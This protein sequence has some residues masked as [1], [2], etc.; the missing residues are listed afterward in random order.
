MSRIPN[1]GFNVAPDPDPGIAFFLK[2]LNTPNL[3]RFI[4]IV[5]QLGTGGLFNLSSF[6]D[7]TGSRKAKIHAHPDLNHRAPESLEP[8]RHT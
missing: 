8:S 1:T 5:E 7:E 3:K 6:Y 4:I 2:N